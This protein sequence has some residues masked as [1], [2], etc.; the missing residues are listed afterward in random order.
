MYFAATYVTYSPL[1]CY[2]ISA[3]IY[4]VINIILGKGLSMFELRLQKSD[5]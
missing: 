3:L 4:L 1:Y 2:Y 5:R